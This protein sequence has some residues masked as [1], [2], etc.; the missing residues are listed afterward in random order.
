LIVNHHPETPPLILWAILIALV[1]STVIFIQPA[2]AMDSS[3]D[4]YIRIQCDVPG[5]VIEA[6]ET[7]NFDLL[8][9][10]Y[11]TDSYRKMW[12]ETFDGRRLDWKMR[13]MDGPDEINRLSLQNGG[14]KNLTFVV[15]TSSDTPVGDYT[16]R[17]HVGDGW[18]WVYITI[19]KS[20]AGEKG[21]L[22]LKVVDTEGEK[23]K[24]AIIELIPEK[25]VSSST[26]LMSA[27][28]G[29]VSALV[30]DGKYTMKITKPGY[31][32]YEKKEVTI[33]GGITTKAGTIMLEKSLFAVDLVIKSPAITTTIG[34]NPLYEMVIRNIGK[35]DDTYR[36]A[37]AGTP[38]GWYVRFHESGADGSDISDIY[39]K[40]GDDKTLDVEAIPP[41]GVQAGDY[42]FSVSAESSE[43]VYSQNLSVKIRGNYDIKLYAEK[44]RYEA[45]KG[46]SVTFPITV[47]NGGNAGPLTSV[48]VEVEAPDGWKAEILPKTV[49]SIQPGEKSIITIRVVP[50]ANIV[51]SEYKITVKVTSDQTEKSDEFHILVKEQSLVAV[52][53]IMVLGLVGG[54]VYYMFRKYKRR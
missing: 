29:S 16:I 34:K 12:I 2:K 46:E 11:G 48:K 4:S 28:D 9:V 19:S 32:S 30:A 1:I 31:V 14:V 21:T 47:A 25:G 7:V 8:I 49:A 38:E 35:S 37:S 18:Y 36:L 5:K 40:S 44:Y 26:R 3:Q 45:N 10:N 13:F 52:F 41:Y 51:A 20:H 24:G 42:N 22:D 50:P 17:V 27:A 6:G 23:V 33:K 53:G 15:D 43:T 54:G 39:L